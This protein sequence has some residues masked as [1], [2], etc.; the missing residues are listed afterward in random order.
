[1]SFLKAIGGFF[2]G[3]GTA[4][5]KAAERGV[6]EELLE[7]PQPQPADGAK[8][9]PP[10]AVAQP[11]NESLVPVPA[12]GKRSV[13]ISETK[14]VQVSAEESSEAD[15]RRVWVC[16]MSLD[17]KKPLTLTFFFHTIPHIF[18]AF[19]N[20]AAANAIMD[21]PSIQHLMSESVCVGALEFSPADICAILRAKWDDP[22][23]K[24][25]ML[26]SGKMIPY[27]L[28]LEFNENSP[29]TNLVYKVDSE[30]KN[31]LG[32]FVVSL[33]R[34]DPHIVNDI[35]VRLSDMAHLRTPHKK[36]AEAKRYAIDTYKITWSTFF[37]RNKE[38]IL[39]LTGGLADSN[40]NATSEAM[41]LNAVTLEKMR[42][43][44]NSNV[45]LFNE[46][47]L[48]MN[49]ENN[50]TLEKVSTDHANTLGQVSTD[51]KAGLQFLA[52]SHHESLRFLGTSHERGMEFLG[53]SHERGMEAACDAFTT[54]LEAFQQQQVPSTPTK[55]R[56][57]CPKQPPASERKSRRAP[58]MQ[59]GV[60]KP[61]ATAKKA[62]KPKPVKRILV[63]D[64][65]P[66]K[67]KGGECGHCINFWKREFKFCHDHEDQ[68]E[69]KTKIVED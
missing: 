50:A 49:S 37:Q 45:A 56:G 24:T 16:L 63:A 34:D 33:P 27:L 11:S 57:R 22:T 46:T 39:A 54:A 41:E 66:L 5:P 28:H 53:K 64:H 13:Q 36:F 8:S 18:Q 10:A 23:R 42:Q 31:E 1:M 62:R 51:N 7:S 58:T 68:L 17:E 69:E 44:G 6:P 40:T 43:D 9:P 52:Q 15:G 2:F 14:T 55:A 48:Q 67:V 3:G 38:E 4:A 12:A 21:E 30:D 20:S 26:P 32:K 47:L 65:L 59:A 35:E 29:T 61:P 25:L 19:D 60:R